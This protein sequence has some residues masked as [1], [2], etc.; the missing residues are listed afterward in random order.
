MPYIISP[1]EISCCIFQRCSKI[2]RDKEARFSRS[3]PLQNFEY[4]CFAPTLHFHPYFC[5]NKTTRARNFSPPSPQIYCFRNFLISR[6]QVLFKL[7]SQGIKRHRVVIT[8]RKKYETSLN[9]LRTRKLE[10]V[11]HAISKVSYVLLLSSR[12]Q[13]TWYLFLREWKFKIF[14]KKVHLF[15]FIK[16][17]I[18]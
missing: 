13:S 2:K 18:N 12:L 7:V 11:M 8:G 4:P 10:I 1:W 15:L 14:R 17:N 5:A 16:N 6:K 9:G 3:M